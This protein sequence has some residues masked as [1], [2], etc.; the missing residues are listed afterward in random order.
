MSELMS[1][2]LPA[3][4]ESD[5]ILSTIDDVEAA[6]KKAAINYEIIVIDDG[7]SDNTAELAR[8]RNV[9]LI[10]HKRNLGV[11]AARKRGI[12]EAKGKIVDLLTAR[13]DVVVRYQGGAN[14]GH[15]V[16]VG[17][18]TYKLSLLPSG[19]LTSGLTCVIAGGVVVSPAKATEDLA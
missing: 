15:T 7:S 5:C 6:L 8:Q 12:R 13:H 18:E 4:N 10:Q 11:G 2:I 14:A 19:V 9:R 1:V 3:Y 16:V 17:D